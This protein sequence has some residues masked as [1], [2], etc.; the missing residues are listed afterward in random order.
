MYINFENSPELGVLSFDM[1]N[2]R[3]SIRSI[4]ITNS[5]DKWMHSLVDYAIESVHPFDDGY[6]LFEHKPTEQN[7]AV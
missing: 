5:N 7:K 1:S 4:N 2:V 6:L 3:K